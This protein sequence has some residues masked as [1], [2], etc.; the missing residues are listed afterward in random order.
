[1]N[2]RPIQFFYVC[3]N[4]HG[5]MALVNIVFIVNVIMF[6]SVPIYVIEGFYV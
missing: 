2:T 4:P 3:R 1:M 5:F 6:V